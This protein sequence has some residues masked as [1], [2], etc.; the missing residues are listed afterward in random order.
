MSAALR[1]AERGYQ[2]SLLEASDRI[3]GKAGSNRNGADYDDHGYHVFPLWYL[4]ME[5][6]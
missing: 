4:N 2:V 6:G 3:G 5:T 1:L